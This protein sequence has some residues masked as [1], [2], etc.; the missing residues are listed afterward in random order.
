[1]SEKE[2]DGVVLLSGLRSRVKLWSAIE[3]IPTVPHI[4]LAALL[5]SEASLRT[6]VTIQSGE[7]N[8]S[9]HSTESAMLKVA[10][11]ELWF[12]GSIFRRPTVLF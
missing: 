7:K 3:A 9:F 11:I 8:E 12:S 1:M 2:I 10:T 4:S 6:H 5:V